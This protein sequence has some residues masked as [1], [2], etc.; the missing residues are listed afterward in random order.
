MPENIAPSVSPTGDNSDAEKH[1]IDNVEN[2][3]DAEKQRRGLPLMDPARRAAVEKSM[4]RKLD[5]RFLLFVLI[6]IMNYLD[7]NNIAAARLK[8]LEKDLDLDETEYATCLSIL[9]VG[10]IL[11]QVSCLVKT[12]TIWVLRLT[13]FR[14]LRTCSSIAYL[15]RRYTSPPLCFCGVSSPR[16]QETPIPSATWS[17]FDS[18]LASSKQRFCRVLCL[19]CQSGILAVS[20]RSV[21]PSCSAAISFPTHFRRWLALEFCPIWRVH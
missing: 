9:Y 13:V 18:S 20:S 15:D 2:A 19:S 11:M 5:A 21:T 8:G 14:S 10:Y 3:A 16:C 7:R 6:Y 17:R 12:T 1:Q 4:K